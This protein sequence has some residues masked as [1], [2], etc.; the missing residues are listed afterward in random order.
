MGQAGRNRVEQEFPSHKMGDRIA[1]I[2]EEVCQSAGSRSLQIPMDELLAISTRQS[3]ASMRL[4]DEIR[5]LQD[6]IT[7]LQNINHEVELAYTKL[8]FDPPMPPAPARTYFYFM[9]RQLFYPL[10]AFLQRTVIRS[11]WL[12]R[13]KNRFKRMFVK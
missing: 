6:K 10:Y 8:K 13:F 9:L 4:R 7:Q 12:A 11:G 3:T 2:L 5:K 1:S